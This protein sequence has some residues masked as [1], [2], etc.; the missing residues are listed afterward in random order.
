MNQKHP[1]WKLILI[2]IG[3]YAIS[4]LSGIVIG[5]VLTL[6]NFVIPKAYHHD[7]IFLLIEMNAGAAFCGCLFLE[8]AASKHHQLFCFVNLVVASTIYGIYAMASLGNRD[9]FIAGLCYVLVFVLYAKKHF[10]PKNT[11]VE[12]GGNADDNNA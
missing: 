11:S 1:I 5:L 3:F 6:T 4:L 2:V 8:W 9:G 10:V 7:G 12:A